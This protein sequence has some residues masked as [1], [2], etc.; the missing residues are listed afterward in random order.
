MIEDIQKVPMVRVT[1]LDARDTETGWLD[2]KKVLD[3]PLAT[4][5]EVGW[6]VTNNENKIVIMRSFSVC[7]DDKEDI[8]GGGA[9][10]IPKS[11]IVK[12]EYLRV[13][14]EQKFNERSES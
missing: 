8:T 14:Y 11:W 5:Q 12:I 10:A 3:A 2:I 4:C 1:W 6:M 13:S 7:P 9:I